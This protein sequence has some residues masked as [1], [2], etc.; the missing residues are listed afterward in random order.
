MKIYSEEIRKLQCNY[1]TIEYK[2]TRKNVKNINLR[3]K[4]DGC[5]YVSASPRVSI[6]IIEGFIT[7]KQEVIFAALEK[8]KNKK[9]EDDIS[10]IKA[11]KKFENGD[12]IYLLGKEYELKV[13][14]GGEDKAF[15]DKIFFGENKDI[16]IDKEK[17]IYM[18]V[19]D[20]T[21]TRHKQLVFEKWIK[22]YRIQ[23]YNEV[24]KKVHEK[25]IDM[26]V[27]SPQIKIRTMTSRWGSCQPYKGIVTLNS[28]L[29]DTPFECLEYVVMHEFCHFIHPNHSKDFHVLMTLLMPDWK[30]RKTLLNS[31]NKW[32]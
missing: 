7:D 10:K 11:E 6:Q 22:E 20:R 27:K 28:K 21:D 13:L 19:K 12:K 5:V 4:A 2:L 25:F 14:R 18:S 32:N 15:H 29:I 31:W 23:V 8:Y 17:Y 26:G 3:I 16:D 9:K 1:G 30:Q 24:C